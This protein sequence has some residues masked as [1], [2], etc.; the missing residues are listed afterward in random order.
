MLISVISFANGRISKEVR[1][2]LANRM[3]FDAVNG[4]GPLKRRATQIIE[5]CKSK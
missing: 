4:K 2:S 5:I 3:E 1:T